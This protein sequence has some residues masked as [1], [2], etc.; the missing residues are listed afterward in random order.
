MRW[1]PTAVVEE[2]AVVAAEGAACFSVRK[3]HG[4]IAV[5]CAWEE[6]EWTD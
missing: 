5:V 4:D 6:D 1:A 2:L 3:E